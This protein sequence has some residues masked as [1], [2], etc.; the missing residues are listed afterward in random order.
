[1][2]TMD[3]LVATDGAALPPGALSSPAARRNAAPILGVLKAHMPKK[4]RVLEVAAGS[5]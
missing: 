2:Q 3:S 1:M 4:G 5:G